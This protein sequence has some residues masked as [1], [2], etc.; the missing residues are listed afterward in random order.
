MA[1]RE[2]QQLG[3]YRLVR[4]LGQGGFAE[5]YLGQ[6]MYLNTEVAIKLLY[7]R[8]AQEDIAQ[9]LE[10]ART[11]AKLR[12][13]H[14]VRVL[15]FGV[16]N[17]TPFLVM[18]YAPGGTLR[19][20]HPRGTRLPLAT[21]VGYVK[22]VSD[23]LQYAHEGG[24]IHR[25][26]KPE[27]MLIGS[28][29]EVLLSDFGIAVIARSEH[30]PL[31]KPIGTGGTPYYMAPEMFQG[32]PRRSSDQYALAIVVYEWLCGTLP[33]SEGNAIQLGYQ[34]THIAVP[35]LQSR[36]PD[37]SSAVE[38]V[39]MAALAKKPQDRFGSVQAFA[40]ALE[41]ASNYVT[42]QSIPVSHSESPVSA[43][44]PLALSASPAPVQSNTPGVASS[45]TPSMQPSPILSMPAQS[46]HTPAA[47]KISRRPFLL[48]AAAIVGVGVA[49]TGLWWWTHS[50]PPPHVKIQTPHTPTTVATSTPT[51]TATSTPPP[52]HGP[53]G[54]LYVTYRGHTDAIT[55]VAWSPDSQ[56][57]ASTSFDNTVQV[58]NA[59]NG[60]VPFTYSGHTD[61]ALAVAWS[62][63]GKRIASGSADKTVQ[64]WDA[65]NGRNVFA[66]K[67]HTG[68]VVAVAWSPNGKH[69]ASASTDKTVQVW[70]A[71]SGSLI[72]T[73]HG[74][75][76]VLTAVAWSPD[77]TRIVSGSKDKTVQVW[78]VTNGGN[79]FTY[80]GHTDSVQT[81]AWSPNGKRIA[82]G[83]IDDTA[84]VWD[85]ANGQNAFTYNGHTSVV[86]S[87]AWSPDGTHIAS[88]SDDK[89]V[90][91]WQATTGNG[92]FTYHGQAQPIAAVAWSPDG[93][94]IASGCDDKMVQVWQAV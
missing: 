8:V 24:F 80:N 21:I 77:G 63:D 16:D 34:H 48:G 31:D 62:P 33:F 27:N 44:I 11:L 56:H 29:G 19:Q 70:D 72:F 13:P 87:L 69:I 38:F 45:H 46:V 12:H 59:L 52:P 89:T 65:A 2:G 92:V 88:G 25:D 54:T 5:V 39:V 41:Q 47:R 35:S 17:G 79:R 53:Q 42:P 85:A 51:A 82:S 57:I 68:S 78:D 23:A 76:D 4:F 60:D 6:H 3:N 18:D 37:I 74:H 50:S 7:T 90:Q 14:I 1:E 10:E 49:G 94:R 36:V 93:T 32:Q 86:Y 15:D 67:G 40:T 66:Y 30:T 84:Q 28:N 91:V 71:V 9:F 75:T 43:S 81:V 55:G 58:W 73:Y 61:S 22:Q 20:R 83:S 26:V 64:V